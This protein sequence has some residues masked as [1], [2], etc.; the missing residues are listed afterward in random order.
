MPLSVAQQLAMGSPAYN[1][2]EVPID[3][4]I[5]YD[6]NPRQH[7]ADQI[8]LIAQSI[9]THGVVRPIIIDEC[10]VIIAGHAIWLA[11]KK[12]GLTSVRG[13]AIVGH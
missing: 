11:A 8:D 9:G 1:V 12:L 4:P 10:F 7:S 6:K 13:G 5:P 3:K 2:E